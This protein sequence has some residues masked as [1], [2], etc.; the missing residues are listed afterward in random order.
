MQIGLDKLHK[1]CYNAIMDNH[2]ESLDAR[3]R[4]LNVSVKSLK[5]CKHPE[6]LM[7]FDRVY[8]VQC[9]WQV[10]DHCEVKFNMTPLEERADL[11]QTGD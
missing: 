8:G 1:A 7:Y 3:A 4:K 6:S 11:T 5:R 9:S 2:A 10:C